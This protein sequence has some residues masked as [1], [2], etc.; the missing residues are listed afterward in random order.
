[1]EFTEVY[2]PPLV[3][4]ERLGRVAGYDCFSRDALR[5]KYAVMDAGWGKVGRPSVKG[6]RVVIYA[7]KETVAQ[8]TNKKNEF[9]SGLPECDG[10]TVI[11]DEKND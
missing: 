6:K 11:W 2:T 3:T 8:W 10:G 7:K 4:A 1:M 9:L 5:F